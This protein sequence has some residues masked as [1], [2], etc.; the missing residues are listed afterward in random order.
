MKYVDVLSFAAS[1][2]IAVARCVLPTPG[3]PIEK[4]NKKKSQQEM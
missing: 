4:S 1:T 2:S 3:E